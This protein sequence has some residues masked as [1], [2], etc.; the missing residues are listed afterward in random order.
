MGLKQSPNAPCIF[1]GDI[2]EGEPPVYIGLYV[3]DFIFFSA[4]DKVEEDFKNILKNKQKMLVDFI[5]DPTHFLGLQI[6]TVKE[7]NDLTIF[8]S[9]QASIEALIDELEL[10]LANTSQTPYRSG[11]PV[12]KIPVESTLPQKKLQQAIDNMQSIVG[13]LNWLSCGTRI[14]I[15]TITN[16]LAQYMN[17]ATPSH[18]AAAK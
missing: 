4:S 12:D 1:Y 16:I 8:L 3:D 6:E 15:A 2:I 9:Q 14:D 11:Y 5:D 13:S 18:V 17:N 10:A 7:E